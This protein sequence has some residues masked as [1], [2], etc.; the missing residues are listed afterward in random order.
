MPFRSKAQFRKFLSLADEGKI[1]KKE[2]KKWIIE[3]GG[4]EEIRQLPERIGKK[5][6]KKRP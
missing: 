4:Y 5:K 6:N 3:T 2:L 1:S